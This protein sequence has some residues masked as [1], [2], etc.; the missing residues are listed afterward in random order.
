MLEFL[1]EDWR[2]GDPDRTHRFRRR[3]HAGRGQVRRPCS[4][5]RRS[6]PPSRSFWNS[7]PA[8]WLGRALGEFEDFDFQPSWTNHSGPHLLAPVDLQCIKAAGVTFAISAMERVIEERARGDAGK[9]Q[10]I[11]DGAG[12]AHRLD[13]CG[14]AVPAR[15]KPP[16]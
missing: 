12:S 6:H 14:R 3:P 10:A 8:R 4:T 15:R 13:I 5:C 1:P 9:A 2:T 11:R 7:P 16:D